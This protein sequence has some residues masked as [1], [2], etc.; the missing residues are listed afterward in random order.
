VSRW[1]APTL[2]LPTP[3]DPAEAPVWDN[4]V[5]AQVVQ[6]SLGLIPRTALAF[7]VAMQGADVRLV[8]SVRS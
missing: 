8:F 7:G 1:G 4:Y 5:L 6:A 2:K 3:D